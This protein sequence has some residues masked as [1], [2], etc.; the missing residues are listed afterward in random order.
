MMDEDSE[1]AVLKRKLRR[2]ID[3]SDLLLALKKPS[4]IYEA[5]DISEITIRK[6]KLQLLLNSLLLEE[7]KDKGEKKKLGE[8]RK[9]LQDELIVEFEEGIDILATLAANMRMDGKEDIARQFEILRN[10]RESELNELKGGGAG[11][12]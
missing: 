5:H 8:E 10:V 1:R 11:P 12:R 2:S 3:Y 4:T 6:L 9:E 7:A